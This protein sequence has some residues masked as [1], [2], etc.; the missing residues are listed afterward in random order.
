MSER[1]IIAQTIAQRL[2]ERPY[3]CKEPIVGGAPPQHPPE[4]LDHLELGT[5]AGQPVY[6]QVWPLG[7]HLGDQGTFVPGGVVDHQRHSGVLRGRTSPG[8]KGAPHAAGK[9]DASCFH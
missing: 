3:L 7:E 9:T 1:L 5:V 8:D 6:L 4:A 2:L